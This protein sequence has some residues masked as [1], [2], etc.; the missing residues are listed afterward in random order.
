MFLLVVNGKPQQVDVPPETPLLWI[1]RDHLGLLGTKYSCGEGICGCCTIHLDGE[2]VLSCSM[3]VHL[4]D[5]GHITTIEG[6]A[7]QDHPLITAWISENVSQCGFCQPGQI[8]SAAALLKRNSNPTDEEISDAMDGNLCRC[9]TYQR[10]R[11]AVHRASDI[12][13]HRKVSI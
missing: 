10:I 2:P 1:L 6:I 3:P 11:R 12:L 7:E 9:G 13:K 4:A 8:M 5:G